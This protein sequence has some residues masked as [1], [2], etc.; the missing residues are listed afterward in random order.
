MNRDEDTPRVTTSWLAIAATAAVAVAVSGCFGGGKGGLRIEGPEL[1]PLTLGDT[2]S[3]IEMVVGEYK[4]VTLA[5]AEGGM[6]GYSYSLRCGIGEG[7]MPAGVEFNPETRVLGGIPTEEYGR[8]C[9]YKVTDGGGL[10]QQSVKRPIELHVKDKPTLILPAASPPSGLEVGVMMSPHD[11]PRAVGGEPPYFYAFECGTPLYQLGLSFVPNGSAGAEVTPQL[12]GTPTTAGTFSC[13]YKVTSY[14]AGI[15]T[16]SQNV[17]LE[18]AGRQLSLPVPTAPSGLTVGTPMTYDLPRAVGGNPP[19]T[20]TLSCT[21]GL[22]LV[23]LG[24]IPRPYER[25]DADF[26]PQVSGT[27]K[28]ATLACT[29]G[30]TDAERAVATQRLNFAI[31]SNP[32]HEAIGP[33]H[34]RVARQAAHDGIRAEVRRWSEREDKGWELVP[35]VSMGSLSEAEAG[36]DWKGSRSAAT[37]TASGGEGGWQ[38]GVTAGASASRLRYDA[39][40]SRLVQG[41]D[42]G[43]SASELWS[44][45]PWG[46]YHLSGGGYLWGSVGTGQ[47]TLRHK[48]DAREEGRRWYT[49]DLDVRTWGIGTAVPLGEFAGGSI[50]VEADFEGFELDIAGSR[51]Q[52]NLAISTDIGT[53]RGRDYR[54]GVVWTGDAA[55]GEPYLGISWHKLTGDGAIGER[56]EAE[57]G[58][59]LDGVLDPRLSVGGTAKAAVGLGDSE[60]E[61][62]GLDAHLRYAAFRNGRGTNVRVDAQVVQAH[63]GEEPS[64]GVQGEVGYGLWG[65]EVLGNIRPFIGATHYAGDARTRRT[66]GVYLSEN[67]DGNLSVWLW[68]EAQEGA[69][70]VRVEARQR[71]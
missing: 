58:M 11:L 5:E 36:F 16:S 23:G 65:G 53:L 56:V 20:Y 43:V 49:S 24:F 35:K 45:H 37:F 7:G 9:V 18:I 19:Y 17:E 38:T 31:P 33:T 28:E 71:F 32:V 64:A 40:A 22:A 47:G 57:S 13:V 2:P 3:S 34:A 6:P 52:G 27:P 66:A 8:S 67:G 68:D 63:D 44:V 69:T 50:K 25:V 59:Q 1:E 60:H 62:W 4:A 39:V 30:V 51:G 54:A 55:Y 12:S 41:Y 26:T 14:S 46:A 61:S 10:R 42:Q 48:D 29:Y 15:Q 70:G 21:P